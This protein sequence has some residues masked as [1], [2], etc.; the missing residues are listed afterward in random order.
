MHITYDKML[1]SIK[2]ILKIHIM[3]TKNSLLLTIYVFNK[4]IFS[5]LSFSTD[6]T[7][8]MNEFLTVKKFKSL[9]LTYIES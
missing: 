9:N 4:Y 6:R 3:L 5:L 8:S 1:R 7:W 2:G